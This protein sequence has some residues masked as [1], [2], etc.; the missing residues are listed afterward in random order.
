M[1]IFQTHFGFTNIGSNLHHYQDIAIYFC[2]FWS[3]T[4]CIFHIFCVISA[5]NIE[6]CG[7]IYPRWWSLL[8]K[9]HLLMHKYCCLLRRVT[10]EENTV[11]FLSIPDSKCAF[12]KKLL[13]FQRIEQCYKVSKRKLQII[14]VYKNFL[15]NANIV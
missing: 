3:W 15:R 10:K 11:A 13:I 1:Y 14:S 9:L 12:E 8:K 7:T 4:P 5:N 6:N 2:N